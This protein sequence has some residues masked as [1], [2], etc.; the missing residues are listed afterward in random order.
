[1]IPFAGTWINS[2][3]IPVLP[4]LSKG[5][6]ALPAII[7]DLCHHLSKNGKVVYVEAEFFGGEGSQACSLWEKGA[8]INNP[9]RDLHAINIALQFLGVDKG[10]NFDEFEAL[11]LG[12][13][14]KTEDWLSSDG[15]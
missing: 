6:T 2:K 4:L 5:A 10:K 12:K 3:E 13:F 11:D 8:M 1:M 14:R 15:A 7:A 9:Q